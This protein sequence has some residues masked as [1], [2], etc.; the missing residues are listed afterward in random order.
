MAEETKKKAVV[1]LAEF[2]L[3]VLVKRDKLDSAQLAAE[4]LGMTVASFRQRLAV[5][6]KR[7]PN[8]F[9]DFTPYGNDQRRVPSEEQA[10][11]IFHSINDGLNK[12]ILEKE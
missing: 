6:R 2:L 9:K 7:Y 1:D 4:E 8:L 3:V 10:I 12:V 5:E 11:A